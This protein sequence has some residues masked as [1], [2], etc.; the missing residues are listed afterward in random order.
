MKKR[1]SHRGRLFAFAVGRKGLLRREYFNFYVLYP[2]AIGEVDGVLI[3]NAWIYSGPVIRENP[4]I[5]VI[6]NTS[7]RIGQSKSSGI[8]YRKYSIVRNIDLRSFRKY[9]KICR[10]AGFAVCILSCCCLGSRFGNIPGKCGVDYFSA[11]F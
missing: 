10:K 5:E 4:S 6:V 3:G 8:I 2:S 11:G 7:L 1:R 9:V